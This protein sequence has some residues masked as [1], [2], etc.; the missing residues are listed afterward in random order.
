[1]EI[2]IDGILYN[3]S[4]FTIEEIA[5]KSER[6]IEEVKT[7]IL[8]QRKTEDNVFVSQVAESYRHLISGTTHAFKL[9]TYEVKAQAAKRVIADPENISEEDRALLEPEAKERGMSV[10]ELATLIKRKNDL[11]VSAAGL[12]EAIETRGKSAIEKADTIEDL[13]HLS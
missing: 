12:I 9:T 7:I 6:T 3:T 5:E 4:D 2:F 10:L 11:F 1:M 13:E 8:A